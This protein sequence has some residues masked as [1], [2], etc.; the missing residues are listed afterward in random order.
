MITSV[1]DIDRVRRESFSRSHDRPSG[2]LSRRDKQPPEEK[3]AKTRLRTAAWRKSLDTRK[4][5]EAYTVAIA[6]LVSVARATDLENLRD[7]GIPPA[8]ASMLQDMIDRG[9]DPTEVMAVVKRLCRA[10]RRARR[11]AKRPL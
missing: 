1:A 9:Y 10:D 5:P 2:R 3:R 4:R 11:G 7:N 6:F 8:F